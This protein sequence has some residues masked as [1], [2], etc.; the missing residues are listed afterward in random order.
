MLSSQVLCCGVR[1]WHCSVETYVTLL[2][3]YRLLTHRILTQ[4]VTILDAGPKPLSI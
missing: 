3:L 1:Q 2:H 4:F